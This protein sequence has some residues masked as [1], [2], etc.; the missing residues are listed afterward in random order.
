MLLRAALFVMVGFLLLILAGR[1]DARQSL[2]QQIS[3]WR[4]LSPNT[5]TEF[6]SV[7]AVSRDESGGA[8]HGIIQVESGDGW[9]L[10]RLLQFD[11]VEKMKS[12]RG[13]F[14]EGPWPRLDSTDPQSRFLFQSVGLIGGEP[15][16]L[17]FVTAS[18]KDKPNSRVMVAESMEALTKA[19]RMLPGYMLSS[20][21][22]YYGGDI[23][24]FLSGD[25]E[26]LDVI[27]RKSGA[28]WAARPEEGAGAGRMDFEYQGS[29]YTII[30]SGSPDPVMTV[31]VYRPYDALF[32]GKP[33]WEVS[34]RNNSYPIVGIHQATQADR[35]TYSHVK[36]EYRRFDSDGRPRESISE[37]EWRDVRE[38]TSFYRRAL[39]AVGNFPRPVK[40]YEQ[41]LSEIGIP[42]DSDVSLWMA[43]GGI[44]GVGHRWRGGT[45]VPVVNQPV[46]EKLDAVAAQVKLPEPVS[47]EGGAVGSAR[48]T[49]LVA[50]GGLVVGAGVFFLMRHRLAKM[51]AI[52]LLSVCVAHSDLHASAPTTVPA[53]EVQYSNDSGS[54]CGIYSLYVAG[55][56]V[57][58]PF[59]FEIIN[60]PEFVGSTYGSTLREMLAAARAAG[61]KASPFYGVSLDA[62][63]ELPIPSLLHVRRDQE[64][65]AL[66]HYVLFLGRH[67]DGVRVLDGVAG[68]RH[69]SHAKLMTRWEG[70]GI[71]LSGPDGTLSPPWAIVRPLAAVGLALASALAV[72]A[73]PGLRHTKWCAP[74]LVVTAGVITVIW[75]A[76]SV[77]AL[78][79]AREETLAIERTRTDSLLAQYQLG[80]LLSAG[81]EEGTVIVDARFTS[82]FERLH[83]PGA[84]N[85]DPGAV[86]NGTATMPA[87]VGQ[88]KKV[89]VLC[90]NKDCTNASYVAKFLVSRGAKN[91]GVFS[92]GMRGYLDATKTGVARE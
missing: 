16:R 81:N 76:T 18:H 21:A 23:R 45:Y 14:G 69:W 65:A 19:A 84:S 2:E 85:V 57:G 86:Y 66:D 60:R 31:E 39:R 25:M 56:L 67:G 59:D 42:E 22:D 7:E 82:D 33:L 54:H 90:T 74:S 68:E 88:A 48:L 75:Q 26:P 37:S 8:L 91:V 40:T 52:L 32:F 10:T 47:N 27:I 6:E 1:A 51:A 50:A 70:T 38:K 61:L 63:G 72:A 36:F 35:D 89:I 55:R 79:P 53:E 41:A 20:P 3:R 17:I 29:Q 4:E 80:D 92:E 71:G 11:D 49:A 73:I 5:V 24:G 34:R 64:S 87:E 12:W 9:T 77:D 30:R 46:L 44:S 58:H 15:P 62:L 43:D 83:I 28:K 78:L 13:A